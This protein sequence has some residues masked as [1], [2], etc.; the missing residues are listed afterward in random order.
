MD[1]LNAENLVSGS[2]RPFPKNNVWAYNPQAGIFHALTDSGKLHFTYARKTR[3]PT[4]KDRY[5]YRMGQAIPNPDLKEERSDNLE[6]G[7]TQVIGLR[8][9]L[10]VALFQSN[11]S[12]ST[13]RFFVLPNV[14]QWRNL[15]EARYLG[16]EL[17][18]RT[19]ITTALQLSTNYTYLSRRNQTMPSV[20]MLDTPRHKAYGTATYQWGRRFTLLGDLTLRRRQVECERCRPCP[21]RE[22]LRLGRNRRFSSCLPRGRTPS[23]HQQ[24]LR[25]ELLPRRG[26]SR[27]RA[28]CLRELQISLLTSEWLPR[29]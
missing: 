19:S 1:V 29:G 8:S 24:Y 10:E 25:P 12:N 20:I 11:V 5:S 9:F 15:G 16:G 6:V 28:E 22:Q 7:Y 14:F 26:I 13:Q 27:S 18:F 3:L 2:V 23:R 17:G 21:A 4:I